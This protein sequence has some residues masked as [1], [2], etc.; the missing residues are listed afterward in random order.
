MFGPGIQQ[1]ARRI[2]EYVVRPLAALGL[3]PNMATLIGLLLNGMAAAVLASGQ[4][5]WGALALLIA[6]L[7]DMVDGALARVTNKKTIFGAFFDSTIDRYSEGL[8]LLGVII[9]ALRQAPSQ[10]HAWEVALAY[11]AALGSVM[12]SYTR[13]RAEGLGLSLKTGLMARPERVVLL[14]GGMMVGGA[15]WLVWTLLLLAITSVFTSAQRIRDV[16]RMLAHERTADGSGADTGAR[17]TTAST[18]STASLERA[19]RANGHSAQSSYPATT[20]VSQ[21][22]QVTP[23]SPTAASPRGA[24]GP[25]K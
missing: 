19:A 9:F 2:A 13:A 18:A 14:A 12:V 24:S 22:S 4:L 7:F 11:V 8:T 10:T 25:A 5:R 17:M 1:R 20:Q 23:E 15:A 21:G 6:G 16:A 3:T